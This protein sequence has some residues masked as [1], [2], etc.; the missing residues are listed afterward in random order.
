[1]TNPSNRPGLDRNKRHDMENSSERTRAAKRPV[2]PEKA[3]A[4]ARTEFMTSMN[5]VIADKTQAVK[6]ETG[7]VSSPKGH[8]ANSAEIPG[9][10]NPTDDP[11]EK[12]G[13]AKPAS[14]AVYIPDS[15]SMSISMPNPNLEAAAR[16]T[17]RA[18]KRSIKGRS[19]RLLKI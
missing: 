17:A 6:T 10:D 3:E 1:M 5:P 19:Q 7:I 15:R 14:K 8:E 4:A 18:Q 13:S 2:R 12:S 9:F 16:D 11:V